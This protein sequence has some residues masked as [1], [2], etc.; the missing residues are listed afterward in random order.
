MQTF[1]WSCSR[2]NKETGPENQ[3][4]LN[5]SLARDRGGGDSAQGTQIK[6]QVRI[7]STPCPAPQENNQSP[8]KI[9]R[10]L[11]ATWDPGLDPGNEKGR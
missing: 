3:K 11:N 6:G 1:C 9:L 10:A 5:L 4:V 7:Q 2:C 8:T